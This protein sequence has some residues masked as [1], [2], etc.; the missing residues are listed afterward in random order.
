[1]ETKKGGIRNII[2]TKTL[3]TFFIYYRYRGKYPKK[4]FEKVK[5]NNEVK[6]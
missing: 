6:R 5:K 3:K 4:N 1:M 2:Y